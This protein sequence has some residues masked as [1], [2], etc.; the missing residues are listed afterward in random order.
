MVYKSDITR[1]AFLMFFILI[2]MTNI[3]G[4]ANVIDVTFDE[5]VYERVSYNPLNAASGIYTDAH[6]NRSSYSMNGT[7]FIENNH[8]ADAVEDIVLNITGISNI[9]NVAYQSGKGGFVSE[10]NTGSDYMILIIPDLASGANTTFSYDINT[11]IAPPLNFT[12]SYSDSKIFAGLPVTV[13]DDIS[14]ELNSSLYAENC[15]YNINI[16]QEALTI[17]QASGD[18]NFTFDDTSLTGSDATNASISADNRTV[19]WNVYN[20]G[21]LYST[22]TT[23]VSY[24]VNTPNNVEVANSY[25]FINSTISYNLNATVSRIKLESI[26]SLVDL[27]LNFDKYINNTLSEDNATWRITSEVLNPSNITINLTQVSLWVSVRDGT[28]TGF[29]NPSIIDNDTITGTA[30]Q[31]FYTPNQLLN[32]TLNPWNNSGME[33]YFN[34]TYSS[35]PI[36]WMDLDHNI[37]NDGVQLTNRSISYGDN[38]VYIKEI[39]LATGYW[40]E[41]DKNI[42]RTGDNNYTIDIKVVNRGTSPTPTGQVV[43]VYNFIPNTFNLTSSIVFSSS[44]WYNTTST[45]ET[46]ND[47]SYNGTMFQ[48]GLI[49]DTN[50]YNSS[51]DRWNGSENI[52]NTWTATYNLSGTGQFDFEDLF[53]TGVDPLNVKE[54]GSTLAVIVEGAYEK[55]SAGVEYILGGVALA[56]GL[57]LFFM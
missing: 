3:W 51:L 52:N 24:L 21:C 19:S 25:D 23:D 10:F 27:D 38:Q 41:I 5:H 6:E 55:A 1:K 11:S 37:V 39:Y 13:T 46:L 49:P 16:T 8:P 35:S 7:I 22:N 30:L 20:S 29:T 53:L 50:P 32:N 12:T 44:S 4:A 31:N 54:K 33:W 18:L 48:F 42:T 34:Y 47:P 36:V 9:Y 28:G 26:N 56:V 2:G 17:A 43:Q 15:I 14:N 40:L 57:L 45:N